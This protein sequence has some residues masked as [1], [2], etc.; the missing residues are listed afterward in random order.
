MTHDVHTLELQPWQ[1]SFY[2]GERLKAEVALFSSMLVGDISRQEL[3][4]GSH[5]LQSSYGISHC[6]DFSL[7]PFQE[8]QVSL[9]T[10]QGPAESSAQYLL[11]ADCP[12]ALLYW[13]LTVYPATTADSEVRT[14]IEVLRRTAH[15]LMRRFPQRPDL[16]FQLLMLDPTGSLLKMSP[17][18]LLNPG[19]WYSRPQ[20]CLSQLHVGWVQGRYQDMWLGS[21]QSQIDG[22]FFPL[23]DHHIRGLSV[24]GEADRS[25]V[26]FQQLYNRNPS[27][28]QL[29]SISNMLF[30]ALGCEYHPSS[31][32]ATLAHHFNSLAQSTISS[33]ELPVQPA[34]PRH[35]EINEKPLMVV[36]SSDL[37][38]HPVGRFWLPIARQLRSRFRT[39][40]VAGHP[41]DND[42]IRS[43]LKQ[44]SDEWLSLDPA[45]LTSMACKIR[46]YS[47]S[48]LLDLG[49]HTADNHPSLL[50]HRLAA[51]QASYLGFYGPTYAS[52][53][54]WWI[55]DHVLKRSIVNSYPGAENLWS[56]PGPSLCYVPS[57]HGLPD[58]E[59]I[60][61]REPNHLVFGSFNHTRKL[62]RSSQQRFGQV[63]HAN[64][65]AVLQFRSHS[66]HDPAVRRRFLIRLQDMGIA[67][68]QLQPLPYAPS[69][70]HAML[71]YGRIH[72][73]FDTFPVSGTTTTLDSLSMGIPVLT[74]PTPYYA[75]TISSAI[76]EHAGLADHV[77]NDPAQLS[78]H[79]RWLAERYRSAAARRSLARYVRQS[80]ICDDFSM[81]RMFVEQLEQ[82]LRHTLAA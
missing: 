69:S 27:E 78:S 4:A 82:M 54:D 55:V 10:P 79:A 71:D 37:R 23:S 33:D 47:P 49:G 62:T 13:L 8:F 38:N 14:R 61:Y 24:I 17:K 64:P 16:P 45:E 19:Q 75:G 36:V 20:S 32:I 81:P 26:L 56:L 40:Y 80:P 41:R 22:R 58:V 57:L 7:S 53:C 6:S 50:C 67:P 46:G 60:Y 66:F 9:P 48:L 2:S 25:L 73:H 70:A 31:F 42:P 74:C 30:M 65:D 18:V 63:L 35:L 11:A 12:D 5:L 76:L 44:L 3:N 28:F 29:G 21:M 34:L 59:D 1:L 52:C 72:L 77:C 39:I 15:L 51:V 68:H 43:E